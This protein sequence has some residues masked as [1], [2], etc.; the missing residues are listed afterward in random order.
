MRA[1][2]LKVECAFQKDVTQLQKTVISDRTTKNSVVFVAQE[3]LI[4]LKRKLHSRAYK[5]LSVAAKMKKDRFTT[6]DFDKDKKDPDSTLAMNKECLR[7]RY[8]LSNIEKD[9]RLTRHNKPNLQVTIPIEEDVYGVIHGN[10]RK[11]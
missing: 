2:Q 1:L 5:S 3:K 7:P 8:L 6:H 4:F 11:I 10:A 9:K